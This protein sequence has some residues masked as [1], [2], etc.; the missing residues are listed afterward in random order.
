MMIFLEFFFKIFSAK[1]F[2]KVSTV[3]PDLEITIKEFLK[4]S[5]F[6]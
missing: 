3:L 4:S 1:T 6:F 2:D 5:P